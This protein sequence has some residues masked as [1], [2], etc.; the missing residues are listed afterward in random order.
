MIKYVSY[1]RC[2]TLRQG[3]SGLGLE[4][5]RQAVNSF[6]KDGEIIAEFVEVETGTSKKKRIEIFKAID[7]CKKTGATLIIAKLDR[8]A[9]NVAFTASL[10]ESKVPFV[11]CDAP[12]ATP[13]TIH[14][15]SAVAE[16]EAKL[17]SERTSKS[18][19]VAKQ[20]GTKLGTPENL[21][22]EARMKGA[23]R[24]K[25]LALSNENNVR[26]G[27]LIELL[28]KEGISFQRIAWKLN[29]SGFLTS[30]GKQHSAY[31]VWLIN[32]RNLS[33]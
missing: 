32:Q 23:A 19:Q 6:A 14:I 25:E 13:L 26:A 28:R 5:Q 11:A 31:S 18:L 17:I 2:S 21:T 9:R 12:F 33:I 8:L 29:K 24:K 20:R 7:L 10:L 27:S 3:Q 4:A 22:Q 1:T 15:L 16:N 30:R